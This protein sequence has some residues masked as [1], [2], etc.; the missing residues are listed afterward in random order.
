MV[1]FADRADAGRQLARRLEHLRG[2]DVVVLG[3]PRGGV[4]VAFEVASALDAPL[5]VIVVRKLGIP[6]QPEVAMGAIGEGGVSLHD[7]ATIARAGVSDAE[8]VA[9][10]ARERAALDARVARLRRG[11]APIDLAGRIAVVVDDGI[12]TGSTAQVACVVARR[13]GAEQVVV[14]VPVAPTEHARSL[15]GADAVVCIAAPSPFRA[16]SSHYRDFTPTS[17]DEVAMLLDAAR[18][19]DPRA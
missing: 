18:T 4:P 10:E 11:R 16:V 3:L 9:I 12:A 17:D 14:A 15:P 5:D 2:E 19:P 7:A 1:T 6:A 13:L 8:V